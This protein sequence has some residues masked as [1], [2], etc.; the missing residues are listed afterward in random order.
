MS[1]LAYRLLT[2]L[3]PSLAELEMEASSRGFSMIRRLRE[4]WESGASRFDGHGE[5]LLG[6]FRE[7]RLVATAGLSRDPYL[8]DPS[9]GRVRHVYVLERERGVGI[10]KALMMR[11]LAHAQGHFRMLR[12]STARAGQFYDHLRFSRA[13]GDHVTHVMLLD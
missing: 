5:L 10:A 9:I 8:N 7:D 13:D 2:S 11:I 4:E 12:L 6:A 1:W 3:P